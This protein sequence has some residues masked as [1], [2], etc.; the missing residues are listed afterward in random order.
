MKN[1]NYATFER[2]FF[3]FNIYLTGKLEKKI[4]R[5]T[6]LNVSG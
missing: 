5:S 3:F 1:E 4:L 2:K 6:T